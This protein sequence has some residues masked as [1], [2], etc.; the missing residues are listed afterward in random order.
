MNHLTEHRGVTCSKCQW[1]LSQVGPF[2]LQQDMDWHL[3]VKEH[4][5]C[6]RKHQ[7]EHRNTTKTVKSAK[8]G[9]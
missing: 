8:S 7:N 2:T 3:K 5:H 4:Q 9:S 6:D 1:S